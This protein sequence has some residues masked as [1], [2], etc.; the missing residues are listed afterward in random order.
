MELTTKTEDLSV[1]PSAQHG[2]RRK[3]A[4][5]SCPL[6]SARAPWHAR[7]VTVLKHRVSECNGY[8]MSL[9]KIGRWSASELLLET[10]SPAAA[11]LMESRCQ[12]SGQTTCCSAL[13]CPVNW[14]LPALP[15]ALPE[16][17]LGPP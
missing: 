3:P 7:L 2:G 4:P 10:L 13:F 5:G 14:E 16:G 8:I 1:I 15:L 11:K 12:Q 9:V 17:L 6:A